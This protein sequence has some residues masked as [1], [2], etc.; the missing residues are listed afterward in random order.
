AAR[1]TRRHDADQST[2][3]SPHPLA[4]RHHP[5]PTNTADAAPS[6]LHTLPLRVPYRQSA[7][8]TDTPPPPTANPNAAPARPHADAA[9]NVPPPATPRLAPPPTTP[10]SPSKA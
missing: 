8:L 2:R 5:S 3:T 6:R 7:N 4:P 1:A 9:Q 10:N